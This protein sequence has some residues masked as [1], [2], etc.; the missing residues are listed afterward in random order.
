MSTVANRIIE[1]AHKGVI[2]KMMNY[3]DYLEDEGI[4][5]LREGLYNRDKRR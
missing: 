2:D 5:A 3:D 1:I 4:S